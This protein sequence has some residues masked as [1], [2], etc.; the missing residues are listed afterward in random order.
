MQ[1]KQAF[2]IL[3]ITDG[4]SGRQLLTDEALTTVPVRQYEF[5][6]IT[7]AELEVARSRLTGFDIGLLE[8]PAQSEHGLST[9]SRLHRQLPRLPLIVVDESEDSDRPIEAIRQGAHDYLHHSQIQSGA[10]TRSI[11]FALERKRHT[12]RMLNNKSYEPLTGLANRLLLNDRLE[13]AMRRAK[14]NQSGIAVMYIDIDNFRQY[15]ERLG[16]EQADNLL[17]LVAHRIRQSLRS[18]DTLA[19]VGAD[20]FVVLLEAMNHTHGAVAVSEKILGTLNQGIMLDDERIIIEC[21][22]GIALYP[23]S[24]ED[25]DDLI[26]KAEVTRCHAAEQG[27]NRYCIYIDDIDS[28][29]RNT[30]NLQDDLVHALERDEFT[31]HFQPKF[32]LNNGRI[33]GTEAL[34]RWDH[35]RKGLLMPDEFIHLIEDKDTIKHVGRWVIEKACATNKAWHENGL[36]VGPVAVNIAGKQIQDPEFIPMIEQVL[37]DTAL[38]SCLLELEITENTLIDNVEIC[39]EQ[40]EQL[41][42][43]GVSIAIDDFGT[44]YSSF[45]YLRNFLVDTIKIDRSFIEH[46]NNPGPEAAIT[47]A[48]VRL[49]RD[50]NVNVVAEGVE[51]LNQFRVLYDLAADEVQGNLLSPAMAASSMQNYLISNGLDIKLSLDHDLKMAV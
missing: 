40:L 23:Q 3:M 48:I 4:E 13:Q 20:E 6:H 10:L 50:L 12:D 44:G 16:R 7:M 35:P 41:R 5:T 29:L 15:D 8:L 9:V 33:S 45:N 36:C 1:E 51:S 42:R 2:R 28:E 19:R 27:G 30:I 14:R 21:S 25:I 46:V 38:P 49:A 22:I 47:T 24:G 37:A 43:I 32:N 26:C 17:K 18:S 31:L 39:N 11:Q 34:L